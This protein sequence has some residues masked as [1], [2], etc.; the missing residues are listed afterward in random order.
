VH[1]ELTLEILPQ[2]T[3]ETC[4]PACLHAVYRFLED[5][6]PLE[7]VVDEVT[8]LGTGGTLA[9]YLGLHALK[10]GYR[11]TLYTYNLELFDPTWFTEPAGHIQKRLRQQAEA[12][13]SQ[14]RLLI[15]T[16][17]H[18]EYLEAGGS[19]QF[20]EL[21]PDLVRRLLSRGLPIMTGLSATYLYAC[22]REL[23]DR[24]RGAMPD[25]V[26]GYPTGHFVVLHG[27]DPS[28]DSVLVADPYH[29][30]PLSDGHNYRVGIVR[31]LGA[32]MLGVLSYD[33]NLL[34]IESEAENE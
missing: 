29:G 21:S 30:N 20:E 8:H 24:E 3:D 25:S 9:A 6:I 2:P 23:Y 18:L 32:I 5:P 12:K 13:A 33:G 28:T 22:A 31:L 14:E 34:V 26:R 10:R 11:A 27:Y 15:S 7:R 16:E 4:G 1:T 19:L 17:A